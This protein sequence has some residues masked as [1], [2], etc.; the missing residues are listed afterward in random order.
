[1]KILE[2][3]DIRKEFPGVLALDAVDLSIE[4]GEVRALVGENGA[5]KSTLIKILTGVYQPDNGTITYKGEKRTIAN[6]LEGQK[7]GISVVHQELNLIEHLTIYENLFLG[8][9]LMKKV[10]GANLI[11]W[12][13][14]KKESTALLDRL[15][16]RLDI[17]AKIHDLSVAQKQLVEIAKA[18]SFNCEVMVMDEPSATLTDKEL[19]V[20]FTVIKDLKAAGVAIIYI[21]HRLE[22]IFNIADSVTVLRDGK[23]IVTLPIHE[24]NRTKL[25]EYMVGRELGAE[26]PNWKRNPE[27][28]VLEVDH[29][30]SAKI[31]DVSFSVRKGEIFGIAGLV[32][33]GRTE[34]ARAIMGIDKLKSGTITYRGKPSNFKDVSQAVKKGFGLVPEERKSQGLVLQMTVRENISLANIKTVEKGMFI[35]KKLDRDTSKKYIKLLRDETP[36]HDQLIKNLSGG[37]QQK[38]VLAKWLNADA[39]ILIFD[40]PT[41]GIDVGAKVEIYNLLV[42]LIKAGKSIIMI[43]SEMPE[44]LGMCDRIA[45]MHEGKL[46]GILSKEEATQ[47]KI[48]HLAAG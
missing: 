6:P 20:L 19:E 5:G 35:T 36:H 43:S 3:K 8:R 25:I 12:K 32:G 48:L 29:L 38:V 33:A 11:D 13:R 39:S 41:R 40:E 10:A 27:E 34:L 24:T 22:E 44:L 28:P 45:V 42:E 47:E 15:N 26:Y 1:M 17:N 14:I 37:N 2:V 31:K 4:P 7:L 46:M 18:L 9:P 30:E 21:S 23:H 16:V